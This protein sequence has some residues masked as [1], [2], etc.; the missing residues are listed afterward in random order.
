MQKFFFQNCK[1]AKKYQ[2]LFFLNSDYRLLIS[3]LKRTALIFQAPSPAFSIRNF[4]KCLFNPKIPPVRQISWNFTVTKKGILERI[5]VD[6]VNVWLISRPNKVLSDGVRF[7]VQQVC[8]SRRVS[9]GG[10][11]NAQKRTYQAQQQH[12]QCSTQVPI[13]PSSNYSSANYPAY[14]PGRSIISSDIVYAL[15]WACDLHC[16]RTKPT[17]TARATHV[18]D[19]NQTD[20]MLTFFHPQ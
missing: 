1:L 18:D 6:S 3:D 11:S 13:V 7:Q 2:T 17:P 15:C 20:K 19:N 4:E 10:T 12:Q 14:W 16:T 8:N 5:Q 9:V